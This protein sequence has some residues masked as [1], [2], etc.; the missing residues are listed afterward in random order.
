MGTNVGQTL[1]PE[2][3]PGEVMGGLWHRVN[4]YRDITS[5]PTFFVRMLGKLLEFT[6]IEYTIQDSGSPFKFAEHEQLII[7]AKSRQIKWV[8]ENVTFQC[9]VTP[10]YDLSSVVMGWA[11]LKLTHDQYN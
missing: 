4:T 11:A 1:E 7:F 10:L 5:V 9:L 6:G 2:Y 3:D 8:H